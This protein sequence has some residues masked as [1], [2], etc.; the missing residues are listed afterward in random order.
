VRNNRRTPE[1][2]SYETGGARSVVPGGALL[3]GYTADAPPVRTEKKMKDHKST[4]IDSLSP[5]TN[6][7]QYYGRLP[8]DT[9]FNVIDAFN[10]IVILAFLALLLLYSTVL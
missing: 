3:Y 4:R 10:T 1:V 5:A 9:H 7:L 2:L 6:D 8:Q